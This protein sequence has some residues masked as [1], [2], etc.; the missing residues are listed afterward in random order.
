MKYLL[1][2]EKCGPYDHDLT[3]EDFVKA[4]DTPDS[5]MKYFNERHSGWP[6]EEPCNFEGCQIEI[7]PV[8]RQ[9][10]HIHNGVRLGLAMM[11]SALIASW[12][13]KEFKILFRREG[14]S[15]AEKSY[16]KGWCFAEDHEEMIGVYS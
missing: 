15:T 8:S 13:E 1:F 9:R 2:E 16:E 10:T 11:P 6:Y 3:L 5:A 4:F 7:H 12:D 14:W